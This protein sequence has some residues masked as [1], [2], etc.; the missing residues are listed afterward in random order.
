MGLGDK[1]GGK[2]VNVIFG[3]STIE[4]LLYSEHIMVGLIIHV[5]REH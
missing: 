2:F 4:G 1:I 3:A 5:V